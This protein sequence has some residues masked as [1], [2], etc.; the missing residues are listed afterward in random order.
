MK[1]NNN[2]NKSFKSNNGPGPIDQWIQDKTTKLEQL[3]INYIRETNKLK[4]EIAEVKL[5]LEQEETNEFRV[6][7]EED[8]SITLGSTVIIT[9]NYK[10]EYGVIRTAVTSIDKYWVWIKDP[11]ETEHKQIHKNVERLKY[12]IREYRVQG[13]NRYYGSTGFKK[14]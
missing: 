3:K 13:G 11:L 9:N 7:R 1:N 5:Q 6:P 8:R 12:D 2:N 4:E 14:R 10:G